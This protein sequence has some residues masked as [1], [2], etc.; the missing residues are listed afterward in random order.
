M[1]TNSFDLETPPIITPDKLYKAHYIADTCIVSYSIKVLDYV[2][3]RFSLKEISHT[4][5]ANGKIPIYSFIFESKTYLFYMSPIGS[6]IASTVLDEVRYI[7]GVKN[8]IFFGSCGLLTNCM[9]KNKVIIPTS[10]YRDE[11]F[12]Y[13][14]KQASDF[15]SI[16]N[17]SKISNIML[18][19][20]IPY[21]EGKTWTT[22]AIYM[23][24]EKKVEQ[25]KQSGC[26]TVEMEAAGLQAICD[27]R[28]VNLYIFFFTSDLVS[29]D[30]WQKIAF[31]GDKEK[32][33]QL[34]CLEI[35]LKIAKNI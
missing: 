34:N 12:S 8:F 4:G 21:V 26:I 15:I 33:Q 29:K 25:R 1:I 9:A 14:Y 6:A 11:G 32:V 13:H 24:T 20:N 17:A 7:T 22:D 30:I 27:Y 2:K 18:Q 28:H 10:A 19:L 16:N 3:E 35:A 23:E 5:T 31:G